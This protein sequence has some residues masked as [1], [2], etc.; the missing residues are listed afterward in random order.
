VA[1]VIGVDGGGT[2][3]RC[4]VAD[5][6]G[7]IVARANSGGS[8]H[9]SS[10]NPAAHLV[11]ALAGATA[12][13]DSSAVVAGALCLAGAGGAG[14][15]RAREMAAA[16]WTEAGLPGVPAVLPDIVA[17]FASATAEPCGAVL[18]AGDG[19]VAAR[20]EQWTIT[21]R[22]DGYGWLIGDH[23]SGVWI[24][25]QAVSSALAA[26][27]GRGTETAL[28]TEIPAA[29]DI[30]L[31]LP[32]DMLT[33]AIVAT[34]YENE[35][36]D[37]GQLSPIVDKLARSGD[38]VARGIVREA[39][40]HLLRTA[41]AVDDRDGPLVLGGGLL[42]ADSLVAELVRSALTGRIVTDAGDAAAG[43]AAIALHRGGQA[44]PYAHRRLIGS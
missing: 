37:L 34:V 39:A 42:I 44:N 22:C 18:I 10:P 20:I 41:N 1:Y 32:V 24:G 40:D 29:L 7:R 4:V 43:A 13:L 26:I 25:R 17:G 12:D 8:N 11:I 35:P 16:A 33:Q 36:G 30:E 3:T 2:S 9:R 19:A 31:D 14:I 15:V 38:P 23:G 27:D 5:L 6:D 28:S 21:R